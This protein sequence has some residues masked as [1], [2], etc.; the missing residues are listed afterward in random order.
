MENHEF[1]GDQKPRSFRDK[2]A[3]STLMFKLAGVGL[4]VAL[5]LIPLAMIQDQIAQRAMH[6]KQAKEE[7][8][9]AA[10]GAQTLTGPVLAI[11][12]QMK[13]PVESYRDMSTGQILT[14]S[15]QPMEKY[16]AF[17]PAKTLEIRGSA[18]VEQRYRGIYRARLFHLDLKV[19]GTFNLPAN[20]APVTE[21]KD[22]ISEAH[23]VML[24]SVSDA[25]GMNSSPEVLVDQRPAP[26]G[27]PKDKRFDNILPGNPLEVDL[28]AWTPGEARTIDF[29]F[30]LRLTGTENLS[31]APTAENNVVQLQSNWKHPSFRG[32]FLPRTR[33]IER[34]GFNAQWEISQLARNLEKTL[35]PRSEEVLGGYFMEPVDV[36]RQSERAVKYGKLFIVLTFATFFL[37][38]ILRRRPMHVMQYLLVGLALTI[39]FLL[40]V[41]LSEHLPFLAAYIAAA[42]GCISLI[43][44][45]LAGV[46]GSWRPASAFGGGLAGLYAMLY[47]I[48]QLE[49]KA[50]LTGSLLLF[51]VL[52]AIMTS[53]RRLDWY[54]LGNDTSPDG[55]TAP[56]GRETLK[57]I[58]E[59]LEEERS[60]DART[61]N[62]PLPGAAD[63]GT[64]PAFRR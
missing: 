40:L 29:S 50:L 52:A 58:K 20:L 14:R 44:F 47:V 25:H 43:A 11:R 26:F 55:G 63:V 37:G 1:A 45:Y 5:L 24:F 39:F 17:I 4:L 31:I 19:K 7:I 30:P 35:Q 34:D 41:A 33:Q 18:D 48:L 10:T 15:T 64:G 9:R 22:E 6:Q 42:G 13:A 51:A 12:Y 46:F 21:E 27:T 28:G 61:K 2:I 57:A 59:R 3:H 8:A 54:G 49:D 62:A 32:R 23:A 56:R 38:E 16:T 36:Y 53:T 60:R